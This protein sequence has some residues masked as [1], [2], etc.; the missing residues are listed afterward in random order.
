MHLNQ[1]TVEVIGM[2]PTPLFTATYVNNDLESTIEFLDRAELIDTGKA[3]EYGLHSRDTYILERRE[4]TPLRNFIMQAIMQFGKDTLMY[5]YTEYKLSQSWVSHKLPDQH[6]TMHTHP[7][8]LISGV[9]YYGDFD[10]NT[11]AICF[12]KPV[13][14]VNVS[15]LSPKFQKDRRKSQ[16][17]W[18]TFSVTF[19]P[20]LL[21]LFPS[22]AY[23]SVPVNKSNKVR[24]SLA[25]NVV[26]AKSLGDENTLTELLF[27][28]A[29]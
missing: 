11:P 29:I 23:H 20:G 28:K 21:V 1:D 2:F 16:Y 25:F 24:K 27:T 12:H 19:T 5:D 6:H 26:P 18:E 10:Q 15:Y 14:G 17:A 13:M 3:N 8:S 7:N 22:Y 4:C 9:F